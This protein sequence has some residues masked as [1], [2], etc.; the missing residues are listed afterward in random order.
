MP[1]IDIEEG[2]E[3]STTTKNLWLATRKRERKIEG[4]LI[5]PGVFQT[6][7]TMLDAMGF[8]FVIVLEI[9]GLFLLREYSGI[10]LFYT[11]FLFVADV[12]FAL[13]KH[14]P[15]AQKIC[16]NRNELI[17]LVAEEGNAAKRAKIEKEIA[18]LKR[19]QYVWG[20]LIIIITLYKV[21][22]FY[23]AVRQFNGI[24]F[25]V[26]LNYFVVALLHITCTGYFIAYIVF[27]LSLLLDHKKFTDT[28]GKQCSVKKHRTYEFS[29]SANIKHEKH[30]KESP[31]AKIHYIE[32][33]DDKYVLNTWG[34]LEDEKRDDLLNQQSG[35]NSKEDVARSCVRHQIENI[36]TT[37]A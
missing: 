5:L 28:D 35:R 33:K 11:I 34:V 16:L 4:G 1:E 3:P 10:N 7:N 15:A 9:V 30:E 19:Y 31:K 36:L 13:L 27:K 12:L 14:Y 26:I 22:A 2:F 17:Y 23:A 37:E 24:V 8:S 18:S 25:L 20:V 6:T 32:K 29:S 21:I